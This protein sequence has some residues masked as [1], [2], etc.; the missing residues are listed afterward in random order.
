MRPVGGKLP[1]FIDRLLWKKNRRCTPTV[2]RPGR[3]DRAKARK[4]QPLSSSRIGQ[5]FG[6]ELSMANP[7]GH[8]E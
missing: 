1:P 7:S 5:E 3:K 6:E 8:A 4:P 2:R